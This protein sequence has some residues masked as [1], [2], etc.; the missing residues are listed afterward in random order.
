MTAAEATLARAV[1]AMANF[2]VVDIFETGG[3]LKG[4]EVFK[5]VPRV[6]NDGGRKTN[7]CNNDCEDR[8]W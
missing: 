7:D 8:L 5:Y 2:M 3:D 4:R 1:T 6:Y